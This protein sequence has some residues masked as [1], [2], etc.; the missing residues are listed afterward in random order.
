MRLTLFF[1][2]PPCYSQC[3]ELSLEA[4]SLAMLMR[5]KSSRF[6]SGLKDRSLCHELGGNQH[7]TNARIGKD[8]QQQRMGNATVNDM[9]CPHPLS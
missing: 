9:C 1:Y 7:G 3:L 2:K 8:F 5:C 4:S 6:S